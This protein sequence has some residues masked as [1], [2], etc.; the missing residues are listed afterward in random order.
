MLYMDTVKKFL[1]KAM[2][3]EDTARTRNP[4]GLTEQSKYIVPVLVTSREQIK[5]YH[6]EQMLNFQQCFQSYSKLVLSFL[7]DNLPFHHILSL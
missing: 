4:D 5:N 7:L 3:V 6:H 1:D 2:H